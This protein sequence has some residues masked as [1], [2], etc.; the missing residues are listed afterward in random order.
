MLT[1]GKDK[2]ENYILVSL[3]GQ[4]D[5]SNSVELDE[6]I[7]EVIDEGNKYI[8]VDASALDYISSAGLGVFMSYLDDFEEQSI[9]FIIF[10]L[11]EKVSNVFHILGLDQLI[12]IKTTKEEALQVIHES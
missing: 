7:K 3:E 12:T 9:Q 2:V 6:S 8:L 10:G 11:S 5:A 1:I 4:V